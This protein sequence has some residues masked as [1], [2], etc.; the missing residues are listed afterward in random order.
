MVF[1]R[2]SQAVIQTLAKGPSTACSLQFIRALR[3][4]AAAETQPVSFG[5]TEDQSEF[6]A[7]ADD[8]AAK[9][10][11]PFAAKWDAEKHFPVKTLEKAAE[12]GFGGILV[13]EDV[14]EVFGCKL[15]CTSSCGLAIAS[16]A[17]GSSLGR[18]DAA[19][20]FESLAYGDISVT[21]Y[22]TIH[23]MVASCIDK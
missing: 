19:V 15:S 20:I 2:P 7:V 5:L 12:L 3:T 13:P 21:A 18:A 16:F 22:L 10:L 4:S 11:L 17:G 8:F 9:E 23:N 14:G 1:Y 6:K